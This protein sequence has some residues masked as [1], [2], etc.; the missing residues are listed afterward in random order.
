MNCLI[1]FKHY[2]NK[3]WDWAVRIIDIMCLHTPGVFNGFTS[4]RVVVLRMY[5][6]GLSPTNELSLKFHVANLNLKS[7][8]VQR[9][10][11]VDFAKDIGNMD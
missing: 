8:Q 9:H 11:I 6:G 2:D 10:L 7:R 3:F 4:G 5:N 1:R